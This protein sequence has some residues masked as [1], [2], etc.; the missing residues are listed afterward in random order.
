MNANF[1]IIVNCIVKNICI[2]WFANKNSN[3][4]ITNNIYQN[5]INDNPIGINII[6][7]SNT[8]IFNNTISNS[9]NIGIKISKILTA[10]NSILCSE[11]NTIY[12]NNFI[13]NPRHAFDECNNIWFYKNLGNYWDNYKSLDK[14]NDGIGEEPFEISG[15]NND[16]KYPLMMPFYGK[17]RLKE[18]YVAEE[19]LY[20]M[21]IV[22]LIVAIIFCLPIAYIW[23][24]K[25]YKEK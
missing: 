3:V 11:N 25:Y 16:D 2:P 21:L 4:V 13:N 23:Y 18:F 1:R 9:S 5:N 10:Y 24:K 22:G 20:I 7:S 17:I 6:T 14:N 8:N 15:G 12:L 19:L